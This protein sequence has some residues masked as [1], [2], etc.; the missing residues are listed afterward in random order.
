MIRAALTREPISP[1]DLIAEVSAPR[2]GAVSV[3]IGAVR[4][5]NDGR[6]VSGIEYS[7][8]TAM[9][10]SELDG[11]AYETADRYGLLSFVVVHR[12]GELALGDVSI[13][14]AAAHEHRAAAIQA[15]AFA[16]EE[17]KKRVPIWKREL[18]T[19][20]TREWVDPTRAPEPIVR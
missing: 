3:F 15:V 14:I 16:I 1:A 19:D 7:A 2:Y 13:V 4:D 20:G 12:I 10:E 11:I 9:A 17:V 5:T 6:A 18:Y 8:Y